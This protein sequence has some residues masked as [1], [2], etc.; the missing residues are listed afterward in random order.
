MDL[1]Q[2]RTAQEYNNRK[3]QSGSFWQDRYHAT[4]VES[5]SHL[6]N[7]M[8]YI[9]F[10]MVRAGIVNHPEEWPYCGYNEILGYRKKYTLIDLDT[11]AKLLN[12]MNREELKNAYR[13]WID[14]SVDRNFTKRERKWTE[15]LVVGSERFVTQFEKRLGAKSERRKIINSENCFELKEQEIPYSFVFAKK[16]TL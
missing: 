13:A 7:C 3:D 14:I 5:G 4:A 8:A 11:L 15:S 9:D 6:F 10:N 12:L 2:G 16:N 1:L